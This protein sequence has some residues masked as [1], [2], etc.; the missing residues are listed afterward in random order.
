MRTEVRRQTAGVRWS[1]IALVALVGCGGSSGVPRLPVYGTV[2]H[3]SGDKIH[4]SLSLVPAQGQSGPSAVTSIVN[5]EYRFDKSNGPT[6]GRYRVIITRT[7]GKN[8]AI[9]PAG[10]PKGQGKGSKNAVAG[11]QPAQWTLSCDIPD[12]GPYQYDFKLP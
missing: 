9:Q 10:V 4:G 8:Q 1:V 3:P 5:G 7:P 2:T 12:K 6:A 11:A